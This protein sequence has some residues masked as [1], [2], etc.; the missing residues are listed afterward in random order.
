M[1]THV[2]TFLA[3]EDK[4]S[5]SNSQ[6]EG[7]EFYEEVEEESQAC[8]CPPIRRPL[9]GSDGVTYTNICTYK[10]AV[11]LNSTLKVKFLGFCDEEDQVRLL[12]NHHPP[13]RTKLR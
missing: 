4:E 8:E 11:D 3:Q 6:E 7:Y 5:V 10:C 1:G 9:C 13:L 12:I 2:F